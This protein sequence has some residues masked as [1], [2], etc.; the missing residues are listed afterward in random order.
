MQGSGRKSVTALAC[1][2]SGQQLRQIELTKSYGMVEWREDVKRIMKMSGLEDRPTTLML[3]DTQL[4][5]EL[6]VEDINNLLNTGEVPNLFPD[7]EMVVLM[8]EL[9][10]RTFDDDGGGL[11]YVHIHV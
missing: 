8:E 3:M 2:M 5:D 4:V 11:G 9:S 7:D 10:D 1:Y 6:F